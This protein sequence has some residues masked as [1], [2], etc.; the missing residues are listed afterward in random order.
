MGNVTSYGRK[1]RSAKQSGDFVGLKQG[2]VVSDIVMEGALTVRAKLE[3]KDI[4]EMDTHKS[5]SS[6]D[7]TTGK[8]FSMIYRLNN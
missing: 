2:N 4:S 7:I 6:T 3:R 1:R 5:A 8:T